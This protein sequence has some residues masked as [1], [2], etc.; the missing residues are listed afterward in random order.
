MSKNKIQ[1]DNLGNLESGFHILDMEDL[2]HYFVDAFPK[3]KSRK[4]LFDNL[5]RYIYRFSDEVFPFFK[6]WIDGSFIT[7][8]TNP[9]DVDFAVFIDH[10]VYELRGDNLMDSFWSFSLEAQNLDAFIITEYP[11]KHSNYADFQQVKQYYYD[12]FSEDRLGFPKGIVQI[13]FQK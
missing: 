2:E 1:F 11:N 12:L 10:K 13:N 6:M 9:K 4:R 5:I 7:N 8:K 3:S